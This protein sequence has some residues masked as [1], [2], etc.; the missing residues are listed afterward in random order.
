ME[1]FRDPRD[2]VRRKAPRD[3]HDARPHDLLRQWRPSG[4]G[5]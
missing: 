4:H 1:A 5:I 2:V 3:R